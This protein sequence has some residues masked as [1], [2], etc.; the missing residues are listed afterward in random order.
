MVSCKHCGC[1]IKIRNGIVR[2][3]QRYR[4]KECRKVYIEGD[5]RERYSMHQKLRVMKMYLEGMGIRSIGRVEDISSPL[6]IKW[7]RKFSNILR[8]KLNETEI[9]QEARDIQI[10]E[11]DELFT[12]Y[13]KKDKEPIYGLLSTESGIKLLISK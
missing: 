5:L 10:L 13:Q 1:D 4:C 11:L 6:I 2:G 3:K 12:Y 7:I 8:K 9:P